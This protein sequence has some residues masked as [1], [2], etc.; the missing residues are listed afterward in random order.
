MNVPLRWISTKSR[1]SDDV[2]LADEG[3]GGMWWIEVD[4]TLRAWAA[5]RMTR[6]T[7][8]AVAELPAPVTGS[9]VRRG[10]T[11]ALLRLV[12]ADPDDLFDV[13]AKVDQGAALRLHA[14]AR[15]GGM[16]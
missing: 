15:A 1:P 14:H 10:L 4:V 7:T 6:G 9:I 2:Q 13:L 16:E 11:R 5:P 12:A 3:N 8:Y